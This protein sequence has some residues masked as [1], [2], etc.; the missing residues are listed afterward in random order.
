MIDMNDDNAKQEARRY[1]HLLVTP[2]PIN[3][4]IRHSEHDD[5]SDPDNGVDAAHTSS[6]P[7]LT[8]REIVEWVASLSVG[9]QSGAANVA[10]TPLVRVPVPRV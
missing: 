4:R 10:T 1:A 2:S 5:P 6:S 3:I 7:R 8:A 9:V